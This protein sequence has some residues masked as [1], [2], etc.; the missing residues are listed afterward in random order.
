METKIKIRTGHGEDINCPVREARETEDRIILIMDG[1]PRCDTH[2]SK[3]KTG[4]VDC[5]I[6]EAEIDKK[7]GNMNIRATPKDARFNRV[8]HSIDAQVIDDAGNAITWTSGCKVTHYANEE[9]GKLRYGIDFHDKRIGEITCS[10]IETKIDLEKGEMNSRLCYQLHV[11]MK[12]H[13][14]LAETVCNNLINK[15]S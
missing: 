14:K 3:Y 7:T 11:I 15:Q 2:D 5:R 12:E 13:E 4:A 1:S 9:D 10:F 8:I 6:L